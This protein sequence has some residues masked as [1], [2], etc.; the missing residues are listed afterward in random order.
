MRGWLDAAASVARPVEGDEV[1]ARRLEAV[2][3]LIGLRRTTR[4]RAAR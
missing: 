3:E 2:A 4:E 1:V